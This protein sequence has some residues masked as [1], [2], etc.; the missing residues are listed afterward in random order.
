MNEA[1]EREVE[2]HIDAFPERWK[3]VAEMKQEWESFRTRFFWAIIGSIGT[4]I[5]IGIWVGTIQSAHLHIEEEVQR[6]DTRHGQVE[7]R[8]NTLEV[9]NGEIKAR[10]ASIESILLEIK[11]D[12]IKLR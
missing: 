1:F 12:L 2:K 8:L 9:T 3:V 5:A 10:L 11:A 7:I 4:F 6:E